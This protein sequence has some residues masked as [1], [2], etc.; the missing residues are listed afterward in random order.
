MQKGDGSVPNW[1]YLIAQ[2]Y[3]DGMFKLEDN[4][5]GHIDALGETG[6]EMVSCTWFDAKSGRAVFKRPTT[7]TVVGRMG[8]SFGIGYVARPRH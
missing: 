3:E 2:I 8:E 6:W 5:R 7:C 1:E 4:T